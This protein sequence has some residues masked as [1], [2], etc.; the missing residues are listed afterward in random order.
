MNDTARSKWIQ[1]LASERRLLAFAAI[2]K[3]NRTVFAHYRLNGFLLWQGQV[4]RKAKT[5]E[6][7]PQ[8][9]TPKQKP[10]IEIKE[11]RRLSQH[12]NRIEETESL[13]QE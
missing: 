6:E 3:G 1:E 10:N 9:R 12:G 11:L 13:R 7:I 8:E 5:S 4:T 2:E